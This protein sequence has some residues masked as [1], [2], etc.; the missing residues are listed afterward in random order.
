[1]VKGQG[2]RLKGG[3]GGRI[4]WIKGEGNSQKREDKGGKKYL[5]ER[6]REGGGV[7]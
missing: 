6:R 7:L 5:G 3:R 4:L 2:T 1:M